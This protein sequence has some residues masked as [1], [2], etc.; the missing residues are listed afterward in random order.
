M[1]P[2]AAG[3][4]YFLCWLGSA[5]VC[6]VALVR[7]IRRASTLE[8]VLH[9]G[10]VLF[11]AYD[12]TTPWFQPWY[13]A[14]LLPLVAFERDAAFRRL[15]GLYAVLTVALWMVP[16]DPVTT[17]AVDAWTAVAWYRLRR[18]RNAPAMP[19]AA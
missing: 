1:S 7:G 5:A 6:F 15:V 3:H 10:L 4:A 19:V 2:R 9:D 12:L 13:A 11:L 16:L 17:V 14:W 18:A 8:A